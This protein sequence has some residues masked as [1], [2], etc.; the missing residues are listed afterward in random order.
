MRPNVVLVIGLVASAMTALLVYRA[1]QGPGQPAA[2]RA[3]AAPAIETRPVVVAARDVPF[4]STLEET[5]LKTVDWPATALPANAFA[6]R[7][8]LV[9]R[10]TLVRLVQNEPVA[11]DKLAPAGT[12]GLLPLVIDPGMRAVTVKVN[13]VAAVGGFIV[14]GSRIDVLVTADVQSPTELPIGGAA[15]HTDVRATSQRHTRTLLQNITVLALGQLLE[16][17]GEPKAPAALT[18]ATL[19]VSPDQGELLALSQLEGT[20]QLVL[21][22]F[23]DNAIVYSAG[24][25]VDDLFEVAAHFPE[26]LP[27][28]RVEMIRGAERLV[29]PF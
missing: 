11:N 10:V 17:N 19:L 1:L 18:T 8:T 6:S 26:E 25:T 5:H 22:N 23:E 20:L 16:T 2:P 27:A 12:R 9:G 3:Q 29:V 7:E 21:R 4:G 13:E 24:K 14:P 28:D 15:G